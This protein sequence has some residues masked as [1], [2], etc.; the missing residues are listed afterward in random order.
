MHRQRKRSRPAWSWQ[1]RPEEPIIVVNEVTYRS[2]EEM[3]DDVRRIWDENERQLEKRGIDWRQQRRIHLKWSR[4]GNTTRKNVNIV[5]HTARIKPSQWTLRGAAFFGFVL[6][7]TG[8]ALYGFGWTE[9]PLVIAS[10]DAF[11]NI[12]FAL[13]F[14][15][16][17]W[18][19]LNAFRRREAELSSRK[20]AE[21]DLLVQMERRDNIFLNPNTPTW[22]LVGMTLVTLAGV[23]LM[24]HT[25]TYGGVAKI[26]HYTERNSGSV[27]TTVKAKYSYSRKYARCVPR[28][29]FDGFRGVGNELCVD[30]QFFDR[31]EIGDQIRVTG[32]TSRYAIEPERLEL[33][34]TDT[35]KRKDT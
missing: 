34:K 3:P 28:L 8:L 16:W 19:F 6:V 9:P 7:W 11:L 26:L 35:T 30:R 20:I 17:L 31:V 5:G 4:D 1:E 29:E 27:V 12:F 32:F 18:L 13:M 21:D 33:I 25:L 22:K 14:V 23:L 15:P 10:D 2:P 24:N